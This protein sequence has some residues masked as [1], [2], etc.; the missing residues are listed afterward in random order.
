MSTT[1]NNTDMSSGSKYEISFI[2]PCYKSEK[3]IGYVIDEICNT[4]ANLGILN[5]EIIGIDDCSPDNVY[6]ELVKIGM[7][8]PFVKAIKFA[9]NF[10]QHAGMI[11]GVQ[12]SS[13]DICVFLDDDGQCP[14]DHLQDLIKPLYESYDISFAQYPKK[15]QSLFKNLGS[16]F[17]GLAANILIDKPKDIEISNFFAFK[18]YIADEIS[19]YRGPYPYISGLLFRSSSKVINV[20]MEERERMFGG[21]TYTL[22]KLVSLWV[23]SFTAFSIKPLR[24]ATLVGSGTAM[25][26]VILAIIT[27]I[28]KL[29]HPYIQV[30]WSSLIIVLLVLGGL[31]LFVLGIIGE[32]IGR[33]YMS[34]NDTPQYVIS[35]RYNLNEK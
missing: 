11:A 14:L 35:E 22:K 8:R 15:K 17:N 29:L 4:V 1:L 32:Y 28:N 10:G 5:Y 12:N 25:C 23:N 30:G 18:R 34:I 27:V 2:I 21:T 20:P 26:G 31:I 19:R 6:D 33:I 13:G 16:K 9:K 7:K 3:T 24:I